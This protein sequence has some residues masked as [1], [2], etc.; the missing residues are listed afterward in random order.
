VGPTNGT[1]EFQ[2]EPNSPATNHV[3]LNA[4]Q[5]GGSSG[6]TTQPVPMTTLDAYCEKHGI[7]QIDFLKMDTEGLEPFVLDGA[8][9]CLKNRRISTIVLE[10]CPQALQRA[11]ASVAALHDRLLSSGYEPR[12]LEKDGKLGAALSVDELERL[13]ETGNLSACGHGADIVAVPCQ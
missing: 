10:C 2:L 8:Q 1:V 7:R 3:R 6:P 11:G 9:E 5:N 12:E 4:A 13:A